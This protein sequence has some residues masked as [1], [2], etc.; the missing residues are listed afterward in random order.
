MRVLVHVQSEDSLQESFFLSYSV[1]PGIEL[2]IVRQQVPLLLSYLTSPILLIFILILISEVG[3]F[4]FLL[5]STFSFE[6]ESCY[7]VLA[8]L[9]SVYIPG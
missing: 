3:F 8:C 6:T 7:I 5:Y 4:L 1:G 2:K 9:N